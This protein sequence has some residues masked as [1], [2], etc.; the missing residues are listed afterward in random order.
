MASKWDQRFWDLAGFVAKWSKDHAKVGAV[1]AAERGVVGLGYNGFPKG[2][3]DSA[4]Q[5]DDSDV[6]LDIV[7][8]AEQNALLIA[9]QLAHGETCLFGESRFAQSAPA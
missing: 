7:V 8:H 9:G 6:K 3:Q 4:D 5:L 1:I 2:M